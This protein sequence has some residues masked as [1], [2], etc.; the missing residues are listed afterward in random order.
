MENFIKERGALL[1]ATLFILTLTYSVWA[2][3]ITGL[4]NKEISV[5]SKNGVI[6]KLKGKRAV[7][8]SLFWLVIAIL[9]TLVTMKFIYLFAVHPKELL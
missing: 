9:L 3:A 6:T 2:Y 4:R 1:G 7:Y 8:F 5:W